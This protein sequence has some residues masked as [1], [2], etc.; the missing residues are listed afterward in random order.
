M[1]KE[2]YFRDELRKLFIGYAIVPSVLFTLVC[3]LVFLAA[4]MQ[5][6]MSG[7]G[8]HNRYVTGEINRALTAY[9]DELEIM[10]EQPELFAGEIDT[11]RQVRIFQDF[12]NVSNELGYEADLFVLDANRNRV[13][14]TRAVLPGYL[15]IRPGVDWG[16][17]SSMDQRPGDTAIRLMDGWKKQDRD[18][19]WGVLS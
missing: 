16:I 9:E 14:S 6:K 5:G 2:R 15:Q 18:S 4:L 12:Y 13:L 11:D 1:K 7:N 17:F 8:Q 19:P 10:A 3:G